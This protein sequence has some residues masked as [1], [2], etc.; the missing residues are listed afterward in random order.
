MTLV[1]TRLTW[2]RR[3]NIGKSAKASTENSISAKTA[4]SS[5]RREASTTT[6]E[7]A[8][9]IESTEV[10]LSQPGGSCLFARKKKHAPFTSDR[11]R[12][13]RVIC[14]RSVNKEE[15]CREGRDRVGGCRRGERPE[16]GCK[17]DEREK[18]E[19][20]RLDRA[21][22]WAPHQVSYSNKVATQTYD[23]QKEYSLAHLSR[24]IPWPPK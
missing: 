9:L 22:I 14:E 12:S 17:C 10:N 24:N 23:D 15:G 19:Q 3:R 4:R 6:A 1:E 16:D 7:I 5:C 21:C 2:M 20:G 18:D 11:R 13:V 8:A